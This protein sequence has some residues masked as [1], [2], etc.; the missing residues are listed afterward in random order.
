MK[1]SSQALTN[2]K[3]IEITT[4][5]DEVF[6]FYMFEIW[7]SSLNSYFISNLIVGTP[8]V[9][10]GTAWIAMKHIYK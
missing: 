4:I 3:N 8:V 5:L 6:M 7:K 9:W 10:T 1:T 2:K